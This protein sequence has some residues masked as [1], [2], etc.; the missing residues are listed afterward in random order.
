MYVVITFSLYSCFT[1][2]CLGVRTSSS[3]EEDFDDGFVQM[4]ASHLEEDKDVESGCEED[5]DYE[6]QVHRLV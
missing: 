3:E 6:K 1:F 4:L 5:Y 2:V